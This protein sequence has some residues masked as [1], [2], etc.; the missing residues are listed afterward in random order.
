MIS[1]YVQQELGHQAL[2]LYV[3]MQGDSH[4]SRSPFTFVHLLFSGQQLHKEVVERKLQDH[5][6]VGGS[7]VSLYASVVV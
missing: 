3:S 2:A 1:G 6:L 4:T 5:V 7:L